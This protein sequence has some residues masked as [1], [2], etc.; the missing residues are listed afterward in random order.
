[1]AGKAEQRGR[2]E[3]DGESNKPDIGFLRQQ[4]VHGERAE[5]EIDDTDGDLQ[6][7]K[8][9]GRQGDAPAIAADDAR[10][11]PHPAHVK[12]Q[13]DQDQNSSAAVEPGRQLVD[14]AGGKRLEGN[15]EPEHGGIAEPEGQPGHETDFCDVDGVEAPRRIDPVA[16]R[17]AGEDAGTDIVAD[18]IAGEAGQRRHPI[19]HVVA[20]DRAQRKQVIEG[21]R[22]IAARHERCGERDV[23]PIRGRE[24]LDHLA[25]IDV[26]QNAIQHHGRNQDDR[27]AEHEADPVPADLFVAEPRGA[28]QSIEHPTLAIRLLRLHRSICHGASRKLPLI[29][30]SRQP[31]SNPRIARDRR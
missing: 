21:E 12:R 14:R 18:R 3:N 4:H 6:Q 25:D 30:S 31:I 7:C 29:S 22:E 16:H 28:T 19:W 11:P 23:A 17:T 9:A 5:A 24:R 10:A 27:D 2:N 8:R 26:M 20:P 15:A 13:H 1:M